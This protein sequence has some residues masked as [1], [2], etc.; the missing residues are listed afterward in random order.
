MKYEVKKQV[1]RNSGIRNQ[2][3]GIRPSTNAQGPLRN[4]EFGIR[5]PESSKLRLSSSHM[6]VAVDVAPFWTFYRI[7]QLDDLRFTRC[8]GQFPSELT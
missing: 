4:P 3:F 6:S 8:Q 1:C 7:T 2:E 5:N